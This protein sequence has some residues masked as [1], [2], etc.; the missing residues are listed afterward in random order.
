MV[1]AVNEVSATGWSVPEVRKKW[2]D[3]KVEAKKRLP[4]ATGGGMGTPEPRPLDTKIA[5]ILGEASVCGIVSKKER[6]RFGGDQENT[7]KDTFHLFI[8]H[9]N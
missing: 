3:L 8:K 1:T 2:S 9:I 6:D 4:S 5:S 7:S